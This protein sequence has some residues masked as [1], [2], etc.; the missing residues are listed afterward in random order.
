MTG[1]AWNPCRS[2][3][4]RRRKTKRKEVSNFL[5]I[6][7]IHQNN[8]VELLTRNGVVPVVLKIKI[9]KKEKHVLQKKKK[10]K[11]HKKGRKKKRKILLPISQWNTRSC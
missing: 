7:K 9:R 4:K 10:E 11:N 5:K 2:P 8:L 6:L 1:L 3:T